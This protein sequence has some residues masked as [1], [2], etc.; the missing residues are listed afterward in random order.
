MCWLDSTIRNGVSLA[1]SVELIV[2]WVKILAAGR[3][4]SDLRRW[5]S[6]FVHRIAVHRRDEA[7]WGWRNWLREDPLVHPY[8]WLRLDMV[9]L[10]PFLQCKP[11][12]TPSGFGVLADPAR[13]DEEFRK[14]S[15]LLPLWAKRGQP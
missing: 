8:K 6:D 14:A 15:P 13:I 5:L 12:L 9:P 3:V 10:A 7:I 2:Q 4:A 11:H 1:R